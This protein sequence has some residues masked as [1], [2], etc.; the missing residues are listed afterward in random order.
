MIKVSFKRTSFILFMLCISCV[1]TRA[2]ESLHKQEQPQLV[3][4]SLQV[5]IFFQN[6]T[7]EE[8]LTKADSLGYK[9]FIDCYTQTCG[10]CKMMAKHVFPMKE[11]GDYFNSRFISLMRDM[12]VGEGIDIAKEYNVRFYPTY[13]ILNPDGSLYC[14]WTGAINMRRKEMFVPMV[15]ER[16]EAAEMTVRY[17]DG[18]RDSSFMNRYLPMLQKYDRVQLGRVINETLLKQSVE[19]WAQ[20]QNWNI[21]QSEA[22]RMCQPLFRY[23]F[24]NREAF[25]QAVGK[26]KTSGKL[27]V[28]Y[29]G[30]LGMYRSMGVNYDVLLPDLQILVQ[31]EHPMV[32]ALY[33]AARICQAVDKRQMDQVDKLVNMVCELRTKFTNNNERL[34]V[35][36]LL[37]GL[38]GMLAPAQSKQVSEAL[39]RMLPDFSPREVNAVKRI[40]RLFEK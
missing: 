26:E 15:K 3:T 16:M 17:R 4:D 6:L 1:L 36:T 20:P 12:E 14:S 37:K 18:E 27:L 21:M 2:Q 8:A 19:T 9:V 34:M 30:E 11:C 39:N 13:L 24:D 29:A 40:I 10:P 25:C 35:I 7:L 23:L 5:G 22:G 38:D 32:D 33:Y 31:E 28:V